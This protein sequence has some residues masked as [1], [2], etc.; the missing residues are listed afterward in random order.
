MVKLSVQFREG[1]QQDSVECIS[2]AIV[3]PPCVPLNCE[4][5]LESKGLAQRRKVYP[6]PVRA[7]EAGEV[8]T[9][10]EDRHGSQILSTACTAWLADQSLF[11]IA[12]EPRGLAC[13]SR[14]AA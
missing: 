1:T 6:S 7:T 4:T 10:I 11:V 9:E 13:I 12:V 3:G 2:T 14:A 5:V 8:G